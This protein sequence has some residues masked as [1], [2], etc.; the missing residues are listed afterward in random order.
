MRE[1]KCQEC[2]YEWET[3]SKLNFVSCPSCLRKVPNFPKNHK[4]VMERKKEYGD[5]KTN[6]KG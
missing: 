4:E 2:G 3:S 6:E 1:T 5:N